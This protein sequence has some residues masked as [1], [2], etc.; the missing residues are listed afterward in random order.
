MNKKSIGEVLCALSH[1]RVVLRRKFPLFS[2]LL[3]VLSLL[4]LGGEWA[5]RDTL[6]ADVSSSLVLVASAV[7]IYGLLAVSV[8]L[9][10][11]NGT[12][13]DTQKKVFLQYE[14]L[15]FERSKREQVTECVERCLPG[16]L[17]NVPR[18]RIPELAVVVFHTK[19]NTM[20]AMQLFEYTELEYKE[21]T[22]LKMCGI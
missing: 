7:L 13:Y 11:G 9:F 19:D 18:S 6:S 15:Y 14:E 22:S 8:C 21:L 2:V 4:A 10:H 16:A 17:S 20:A 3:V 1:G 12:P 5:M